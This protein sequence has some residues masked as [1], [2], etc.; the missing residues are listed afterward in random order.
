MVVIWPKSEIFQFQNRPDIIILHAFK[1]KCH[2][3]VDS[4]SSAK[5][6]KWVELKGR[7]RE[8][9]AKR[10][11]PTANQQMFWL[12]FVHAP[13]NV[14]IKR[15]RRKLDLIRPK[16]RNKNKKNFVLNLF[17]FLGTRA[18]VTFAE[19]GICLLLHFSIEQSD[20]C[21]VLL[22]SHACLRVCVSECV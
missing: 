20:F 2:F 4:R 12:F 6:I 9:R 3:Y 5:T 1:C 14:Y 13:C 16:E 8:R 15:N 18:G 7:Q 21:V 22:C 19:F 17:W 11:R 10:F